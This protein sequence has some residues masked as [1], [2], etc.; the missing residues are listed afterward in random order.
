MKSAG[1][2]ARVSILTRQTGL[3]VERARSGPLGGDQQFG[4]RLAEERVLA[5]YFFR[6]RGGA[7]GGRRGLPTAP[8][9]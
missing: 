3:S 7:P 9:E 4:A 2:S 1:A 6:L 5:V 8:T